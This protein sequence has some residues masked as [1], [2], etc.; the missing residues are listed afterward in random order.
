MEEGQGLEFDVETF[1]ASI[2]SWKKTCILAAISAK[3]SYQRALHLAPWEANIYTDIAIT[4]DLISSLTMS[5]GNDFNDWYDLSV[6]STYIDHFILLYICSV[7]LL[8]FLPGS[9]QRRWLWV[10]CYLRVTIMSFG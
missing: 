1:N 10:L 3:C 4:A 9:Y 2:L 8:S 5:D 6:F 7:N